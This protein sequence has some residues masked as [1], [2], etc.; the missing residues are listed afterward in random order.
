MGELQLFGG[1]SDDII[2]G[3]G[4]EEEHD[5]SVDAE[6]DAGRGGHCSKVGKKLLGEGVGVLAG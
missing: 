6:G 1:E 4:I 3:R 2:D 5:E